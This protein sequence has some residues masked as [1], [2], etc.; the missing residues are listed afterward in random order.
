[1]SEKKE[2]QS[3]KFKESVDKVID[4]IKETSED[5]RKEF[6]AQ[7]GVF[8]KAAAASMAPLPK[9][10]RKNIVEIHKKLV[11]TGKEVSDK[12][13]EAG[14]VMVD[15]YLEAVDNLLKEVS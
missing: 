15:D 8:V 12:L 7:D 10:A 5:M 2:K 13:V 14:K 1:M 11:E 6:K 9:E 4:N 3:K